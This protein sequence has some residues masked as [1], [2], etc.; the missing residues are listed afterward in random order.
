MS[1]GG[2]LLLAF[3]GTLELAQA[4][5][6]FRL[7]LEEGALG[8]RSRLEAFLAEAEALLPPE[9]K[10]RIGHPVKVRFEK[11]DES[12][13]FLAPLCPGEAPKA[14]TLEGISAE[15]GSQRRGEFKPGR[16]QLTLNSVMIP[17]IL[18][19]QEAATKYACGHA[20]LYQLALGTVLHE[21]SHA[22]DFSNFKSPDRLKWI[23][24]CQ[25]QLR[26]SDSLDY[27]ERAACL[28]VVESQRSVSDRLEFKSLMGFQP[29]LVAEKPRNFD[30]SRS[31]DRYE[32]TNSAESFSVN[33]EYFLLDPEYACRRPVVYAFLKRHFNFTPFPARSCQVNT[34]VQLSPGALGSEPNA[35]V[36]LNPDRI[37]QIH[38]LFA[39]QGK[40]I[41]SRWGHS[42]Y[43]IIVCAKHR[44]T[45]GPECMN[46]IQEHIVVSYRANP[47]GWVINPLAGLNGTYPSQLFLYRFYPTIV[48]EYTVDEMRNLISLPL[49]LTPEQ[50]QT[51]V[52][53]VLE[54]HWEYTGKYYFFSNNCAT[55]AWHLLKGV[56]PDQP[57]LQTWDSPTPLG[58]YR[59]LAWLKLIDRSLVEDEALA[60]KRGFYF[61]SKREDFEGALEA[62]Q[63]TRDSEGYSKLE[64][65]LEKSTATERLGWFESL[66]NK[67]LAPRFFILE[68]LIFR[69]LS[70]EY[71]RRIFS[72]LDHPSDPRIQEIAE[73]IREQIAESHPNREAEKG[74][75]VALPGDL[76]VQPSPPSTS[77]PDSLV[78]LLEE[79]GEILK[80]KLI[81]LT[82]EVG[83]SQK[84]RA[85]FLK[86]IP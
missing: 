86:S 28:G 75:G 52:Y 61:G 67:K 11:W 37:Y 72:E 82:T 24:Y 55:E 62:I 40:Q 3:F 4:G 16:N 64:D 32:Y 53:R 25:R 2:N 83:L 71:S 26:A 58:M 8:N 1:L 44:K 33:M 29:D 21:I 41:M 39:S 85:I 15:R 35:Q 81:S 34:R 70:S 30:R 7:K 79:L 18:A 84:N 77:E 10:I 51:F 27:R 46:D 63:D 6:E 42:M 9:L 17:E 68:T 59:D 38:F 54:Q 65:F 57:L 43:R 80:E 76:P 74:Y 12:S 78:K 49:A 19:G 14:G 45:I 56:F 69:K 73:K 48:N 66:G 23:E 60:A 47:G 20:D 31:P 50:K 36:D 22:Y 5:S 13:R